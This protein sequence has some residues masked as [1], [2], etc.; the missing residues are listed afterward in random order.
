MISQLKMDGR[1]IIEEEYSSIESNAR[2]CA[3]E[4]AALILEQRISRDKEHVRSIVI[5]KFDVLCKRYH[6]TDQVDR[7]ISAH[8]SAS[9]WAALDSC[10]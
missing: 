10:R 8:H 1:L 3:D 9:N 4:S 5:M 6:D 7:S 2:L